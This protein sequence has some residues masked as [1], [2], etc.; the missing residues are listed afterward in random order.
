[1]P[2][3]RQPL[4]G[5]PWPCHAPPH[6]GPPPAH[7]PDDPDA[8]GLLLLGLPQHVIEEVVGRASSGGCR[9]RPKEDIK[10]LL[11]SCKQLRHTMLQLHGFLRFN[12]SGLEDSQLARAERVATLARARRIQRLD[13]TAAAGQQGCH[14]LEAALQ[15]LA[16]HGGGTAVWE[17]MLVRAGRKWGCI[18]LAGG[19]AYHAAPS[20]LLVCFSNHNASPCSACASTSRMYG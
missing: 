5:L 15:H 3:W 9:P 10:A 20:C 17:L 19:I 1:M 12:A 7:D 11:T 4:P 13:I 6:A 8:P 16:A 18:C 14:R 2:W